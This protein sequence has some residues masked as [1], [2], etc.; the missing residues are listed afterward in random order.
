MESWR[1]KST[2]AFRFWRELLDAF[3]QSAEGR[4]R[5][6]DLI[7]HLIRFEKKSQDTFKYMVSRGA[8]PVYLLHVLLTLCDEDRVKNFVGFPKVSTLELGGTFPN[9]LGDFH[10]V[11][12]ADMKKIEVALPALEKA[13]LTSDLAQIE[14]LRKHFE[15]LPEPPTRAGYTGE[16]AVMYAEVTV[17]NP[18]PPPTK[19]RPGEHFFNTAMVLLAR[20]VEQTAARAAR[21]SSIVPLLNTFCPATYHEYP[22]SREAVRQRVLSVQDR[23]EVETYRQYFEQWFEEWKASIQ[24]NPFPFNPWSS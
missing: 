16:K 4:R 15:A 6:Q 3:D 24:R 1:K 23:P 11:T 19:G 17:P 2:I 21:Y 10:L 13:G 18:K 5:H 9:E 7:A 12:E 8:D 22:L 14:R 20:H